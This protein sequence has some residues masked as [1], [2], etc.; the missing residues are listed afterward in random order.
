[1]RRRQA[2]DLKIARLVGDRPAAPDPL[3][4]AAQEDDHPRQRV[5]YVVRHP[6]MDEAG[7]LREG[8]SR[9]EPAQDDGAD[10]MSDGSAD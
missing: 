7:R 8:G 10:E 9:D 4:V 5:A 6:T 2:R 1:M 3:A